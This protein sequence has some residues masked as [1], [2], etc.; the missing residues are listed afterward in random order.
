M[1]TLTT[2]LQ[3][4]GQRPDAP[5]RVAILLLSSLTV[6]AGATIAATLPSVQKAFAGTEGAPWLTRLL[7]TLPAL[8]IGLGA[9]FAGVVIDRF[10]RRR[11]LLIGLV[12]Y[13]L[14]G[15]SGYYL[16]FLGLESLPLLLAGRALLG[17]AVAALMTTA[18]TLIGDY[19]SGAARDR[20]FGQQ[21]AV[22]AGGGLVYITLGGALAGVDWHLP[23]LIYALPLAL[24]PLVAAKITEPQAAEASAA[25]QAPPI[26]LRQLPLDRLLLIYATSFLA[27]SF[28]FLVP[29]QIPF[30]VEDVLNGTPFQA[31]I[32]LGTGTATATLMA[33]SYGRL[34]RWLR[35]PSVYVLC[36]G[37]T[38]LGFLWISQV[39]AYA[40]VLMALLVVGVGF[41]LLMP[42]SNLW[43]TS[44]APVAYRGRLVSLLTAAAFLGQFASP[45]FAQ[46]LLKVLSLSELFLTAGLAGLVLAGGMLLYA[47]TNSPSKQTATE[48]A[49]PGSSSG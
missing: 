7:L 27:M 36:F 46:P 11:L 47:K 20:F 37:M 2:P 15:S 35:F 13:A 9:P 25:S 6:M 17:L 43:L 40:E 39:T 48:I 49:S 38:G 42:N 5:T 19:F 44:L 26:Q 1:S 18:T 4:G 41:G 24:L 34:R 32:A 14:A 31:G 45:L 3:P 28:F 10:G 21:G 30:F 12:L 16:R 8:F 33:M 23:F 29:V 22:M